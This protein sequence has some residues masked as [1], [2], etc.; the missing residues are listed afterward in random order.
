MH[1]ER[2]E[3]ADLLVGKCVQRG[4]AD[5]RVVVLG[6]DEALD[7]HLEPLARAA[8]EDALLLERP[9][10]LQDAADVVDRRAAQVRERRRGDHRPDAVARE[11][12]EQQ[13]AVDVAADEVRALDAVVAG[14]DRAGQVVHARRRA[15]CRGC[16][17]AAPRRPWS[18]ARSAAAGPCARPRSPSG[19]RACARRCRT[20][21]CVATSS[22]A[23]LKIS[24]VGE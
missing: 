13:R 18:T 9:D 1:G 15:A 4:A 2:G 19:R 7:L 22:S 12:L 8:D 5:D 10:D 17:P 6:D 20:A 14:A 23:R 3:L 24:P 21:T 16:G 11:E